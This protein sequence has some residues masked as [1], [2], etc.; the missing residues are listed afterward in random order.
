MSACEHAAGGG[1]FSASRVDGGNRGNS[2]EVAPD[3][4]RPM[5]SAFGWAKSGQPESEFPCLGCPPVV[6]CTL[7]EQ[8]AHSLVFDVR[9]GDS[10]RRRRA[11]RATVEFA[12][13]GADYRRASAQ[14]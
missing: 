11:C 7:H 3:P 6:N 14:A 1:L 5:L 2:H 9:G 10:V 8:N 13:L 12:F 4:S